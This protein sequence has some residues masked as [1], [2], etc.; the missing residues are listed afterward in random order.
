MDP[1]TLFLILPVILILLSLGIFGLVK[2]APL[3]FWFGGALSAFVSGFIEGTPIGSPTGGAIAVA[4]GQAHADLG[5]RHILIEI[6]HL[7]AIPLLTGAADVRTYQKTNSFPNVFAPGTPAV[8]IPKQP[9]K[10]VANPPAE[11]H[12]P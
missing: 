4:D 12:S 10:D 8:P 2:S 3:R 11:P 1:H 6:A 5:S 9:L 7:L